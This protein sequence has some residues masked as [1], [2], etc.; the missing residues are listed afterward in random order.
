MMS[1]GGPE[2]VHTRSLVADLL[3]DR[4]SNAELAVALVVLARR[5]S[6]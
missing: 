6:P 5:L 2:Q 1:A 3:L 4:L